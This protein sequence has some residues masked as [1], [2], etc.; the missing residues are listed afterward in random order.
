M[1]LFRNIFEKKAKP[2]LPPT[3]KTISK[4]HTEINKV[5]IV[6]DAQINRYVLKSYIQHINPNI[7]IEEA[8]SG[9]QAVDM[10]KIVDYD[11]IFMDVKMPG[12]SGNEATR[13]ILLTKPETIIYGVTG[14]IENISIKHAI[15][16]G[17]KRCLAKPLE[18]SDIEKI[19]R[20]N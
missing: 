9:I 1:K 14:Q 2:V 12:M 11:I 13:T 15:D 10:A 8:C 20:N 4:I 5:L 7:I 19:L 6:D 18:R 3:K 16:S 17:M